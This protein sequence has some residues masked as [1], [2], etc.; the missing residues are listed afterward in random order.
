[1]LNQPIALSLVNLMQENFKLKFTF[2]I[3][4]PI[5][6]LKKRI[7]TKLCSGRNLTKVEG[8]K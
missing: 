4:V 7:K 2:L 3:Q 5:L 1:M 8:E 6:N